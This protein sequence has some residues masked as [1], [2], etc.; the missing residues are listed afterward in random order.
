[1]FLNLLAFPSLG[2]GNSP[3]YEWRSV[4]PISDPKTG[5][6]MGFNFGNGGGFTLPDGTTVN[7]G[8]GGGVYFAGHK[9]EGHAE[10]S[11][12]VQTLQQKL[13]G[14]V[15]GSINWPE[16]QKAKGAKDGPCKYSHLI[17]EK[18]CLETCIPDWFPVQASNAIMTPGKCPSTKY[19]EISGQY[20]ADQLKVDIKPFLDSLPFKVLALRNDED[21]PISLSKEVANTTQEFMSATTNF[22]NPDQAWKTFKDTLDKLKQEL[23]KYSRAKDEDTKPVPSKCIVQRAVLENGT[24]CMESCNS[25]D[26][27]KL[28]L[29][30]TGSCSSLSPS[31]KPLK[32]DVKLESIVA[33]NDIFASAPLVF[34]DGSPNKV[35]QLCNGIRGLDNLGKDPRDSPRDEILALIDAIDAHDNNPE[36]QEMVHVLHEVPHTNHK[37]NL[38]HLEATNP[39]TNCYQFRLP[40]GIVDHLKGVVKRGSCH[41]MGGH[42]KSTEVSPDGKGH[43]EEWTTDPD[44]DHESI[45]EPAIKDHVKDAVK[46]VKDEASTL[47]NSTHNSVKDAKSDL[48]SLFQTLRKHVETFGHDVMDTGKDFVKKMKESLNSKDA[49]SEVL[50]LQHGSKQDCRESEPVFFHR[51]FRDGCVEVELKKCLTESLG[52][53]FGMKHGQ[54][55]DRIVTASHELLA[56]KLPLPM[57]LGYMKAS[58]YKYDEHLKAEDAHGKANLEPMPVLWPLK[59]SDAK[60]IKNDAPHESE[61]ETNI[62][63]NYSETSASGYASSAPSWQKFMGGNGFMKQYATDYMNKFAGNQGSDAGKTGNTDYMK[64]YASKYTGGTDYMNKF[65]GNQGSDAGKTGN[66]DYMKQYASKYTGGTDYMNKFAGNQGSDAGKTGGQDWQGYM[67]GDLTHTNENHPEADGAQKHNDKGPHQQYKDLFMSK[68][69][70]FNYQDYMPKDGFASYSNPNGHPSGPSSAGFEQ[71][72]K[73]VMNDNDMYCLGVKCPPGTKCVHGVCAGEQPQ[74]KDQKQFVISQ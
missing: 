62:M 43:V 7:F 18:F 48:G 70:K 66:T 65:A 56:F 33:S 23:D 29:M 50:A 32:K 72:G 69:K 67:S 20:D 64:Q 73:S 55:P 57:N 58:L 21:S 60:E 71:I 22:M 5:A 46:A 24:K 12:N 34:S 40:N 14:A 51:V 44:R 37:S 47:K 36:Y 26:V 61:H 17:L 63:P 27:A 54:C 68:F 52:Y 1:M 35:A 13:Q 25:P 8:G 45:D 16:A 4:V 19:R 39:E 53:L 49:L 3:S 6:N 9:M 38:R 10:G 41:E 42:R 28:E 74:Q 11:I 59:I 2:V 15:Y 31:F 30:E